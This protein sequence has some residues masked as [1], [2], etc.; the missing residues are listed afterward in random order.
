VGVALRALRAVASNPL[1]CAA[2]E[3]Q[4]LDRPRRVMVD[5]ME[6]ADADAGSA[7][8]HSEQTYIAGPS[9]GHIW[10]RN[11]PEQPVVQCE[12]RISTAREQTEPELLQSTT[13]FYP[14]TLI[15]AALEKCKKACNTC[16]QFRT[17]GPFS[18]GYISPIIV[19]IVFNYDQCCLAQ[20]TSIYR[21]HASAS[22]ATGVAFNSAVMSSTPTTT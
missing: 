8:T 16:A 9:S 2:H 18:R 7:C 21:A 1:C 6:R 20:P 22:F 11:Y 15:R 4:P 14:T 19:P 12:N 3:S 17:H 13:Y 5:T 10:L